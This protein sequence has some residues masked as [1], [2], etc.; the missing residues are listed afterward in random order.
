[1][2]NIK[3]TI[4]LVMMALLGGTASAQDTIDIITHFEG[5]GNDA[6]FVNDQGIFYVHSNQFYNEGYIGFYSANLLFG[7]VGIPN[8]S[9]Q[10]KGLWNESFML[11]AEVLPFDFDAI[12]LSSSMSFPTS[13]LSD[14]QLIGT[15]F[16]I[17]F[18]RAGQSGL[19][20]SQTGL[21]RIVLQIPSIIQTNIGFSGGLQMDHNQI[22]LSGTD[23]RASEI[24]NATRLEGE[25]NINL[26]LGAQYTW[27]NAAAGRFAR[28]SRMLGTYSRERIYLRSRYSVG[29]S[30][31]VADRDALPEEYDLSLSSDTEGFRRFGIE[32]GYGSIS[33]LNYS[34]QNGRFVP[35]SWFLSWD[36][37]I[38]SRPGYLPDTD[39]F[40]FSNLSFNQFMFRLEL[41]V[42]FIN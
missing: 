6:D 2:Q 3:I 18:T 38:G 7:T 32:L 28:E 30:L 22:R 36:V 14:F 40:N 9:L 21:K 5:D 12:G 17:H 15:A 4:A 8:I 33:A 29:S 10:Y 13:I 41:G 20:Y 39:G 19:T 1:M 26:V 34:Y 35:K 42:G 25:R 27:T 23:P 11:E 31:I 37:S 16:P 24:S